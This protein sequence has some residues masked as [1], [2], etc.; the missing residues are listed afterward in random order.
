[1][2]LGLGGLAIA[3][4]DVSA[5]GFHFNVLGIR[6]SSW[7][8]YK[9]FRI[10]I[11]ATTAAFWLHDRAVEPDRTSWRLLHRWAPW[12]AGGIV[13]A[14][15]A[16]AIHFGI[17]VA[18][19]ADGY[20]YVSEASLWAQG[21]LVVADPLADVE[22]TLGPAVAPLGYRLAPAPGAIV[23]IY[24][25]GLPI[26]M[27]IAMKLAG[28]SAVY[29]VVPLLGGLVVWL[30]Y[31]LGA[32]VHGPLTGL[33]AA[34]LFAS[35]PLFMFHTIA[36]MSDVPVT[37]WWLLAWVLAM[38]PSTGVS[39]KRERVPGWAPAGA[40][41]AVSAAIVT[42]PNLVPLAIVLAAVVAAHKPRLPRLALFAAG[43]IPGCL[44]VGAVN[45]HLYGSPLAS[46]YGP[47]GAFYAWR[48]WPENLR[49]Y[50]WLLVDLNSPG[51]LLGLLAPF[52]ARVRF[53]LAML[54]F[55]LVLLVCYL[56]YLVQ[57]G[58]PFLRFL[59]P[60]LPLLFVLA[61]AVVVRGLERLP[62]AFRGAAVLLLCNLLPVWY[63]VKADRLSVFDIQRVERRYP[64][65]GDQIDRTFP[66]NA[67]VLTVGHSG[68]VRLYGKR[69]TARWDFIEPARFD[70]TVDV[71]KRAGYEPYLLLEDSE[72]PVF[73]T[74]LGNASRYGALDW[75]PAL[76][77]QDLPRV[78]VYNL[79]DRARHRAGASISTIRIP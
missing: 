73:R 48:N 7:E 12:I 13:A 22:P 79:A 16:V 30:T 76:E 33:I 45:A 61:T 9:P 11:L 17:F 59:L 39:G 36:P 24:A 28:P 15:V 46:G 43:S 3:L 53:A 26:A 56:F 42:R 77:Y 31:V 78:D 63:V 32:R 54:A 34:L 68:S 57:D 49:Q 5:G 67:I 4:W 64:A 74:L 20:G 1:M 40:G 47:L 69:V 50:S 6:V 58:W 2:A 10:G 27:A 23:P 14:S 37:A 66:A 70:D 35:S 72:M 41:L 60:A 62:V 44:I 52:V 65:V 71:L 19:G 8:A 18:G 38:S 51:L 21:Q 55:S 75:P 25:P 29:Y